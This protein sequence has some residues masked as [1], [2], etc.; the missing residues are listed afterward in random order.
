MIQ[1]LCLLDP[2]H[3]IP[4]SAQEVKPNHQGYASLDLDHSLLVIEILYLSALFSLQMLVEICDFDFFF[5]T[6]K[7]S[8][9]EGWVQEKVVKSWP[10][11]EGAQSFQG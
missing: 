6:D 11:V 9:Q 7:Q 1:C 4:T 8:C 10:F 5:P 3:K 2:E